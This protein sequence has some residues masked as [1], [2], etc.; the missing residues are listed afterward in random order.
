MVIVP[1]GSVHND[2]EEID[3]EGFRLEVNEGGHLERVTREH[4]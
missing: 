4:F 3:S 1:E 2:I